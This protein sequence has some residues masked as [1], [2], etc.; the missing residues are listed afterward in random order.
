MAS[1]LTWIGGFP[2]NFAGAETF[3]ECANGLLFA[4]SLGAFV[5]ALMLPVEGRAQV[6]PL[7]PPSSH[8]SRFFLTD[9]DR[10][11]PEI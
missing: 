10:L 4:H 9:I 5:S 2:R 7:R 3:S 1:R 6:L 11:M 8:R